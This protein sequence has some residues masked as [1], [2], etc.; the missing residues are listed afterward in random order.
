MPAS[1]SK[2]PLYSQVHKLLLDRIL[3]GFWKPGEKLPAETALAQH[4]GVS[5]GTVR[6]AVELLVAE[7]ILVRREG[8]GTFVTTYR[9]AGYWNRFQPFDTVEASERY[10][11]RRFILLETKA[12]PVEA[13]SA[14]GLADGT[15]MIHIV[16]HMVRLSGPRK[17]I[18]TIVTVDEL[19]LRCDVFK[20]L[21]EA[22]LL[23]RFL[24]SDS[25]YKFYDREF[26]VVVTRQK[27]AV[28]CEDVDGELARALRLS[29]PMRALRL[30][31]V[32]YA[33]GTE[34]VEYRI[35]RSRAQEARLIFDLN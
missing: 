3:T 7:N 29:S 24:P 28:S 25:L 18:E 11:L 4:F 26:G 27:C 31:R 12:S 32:S 21:N 9:T 17:S 35:Y 10:D 2:N 34:P 33:F 19:Y 22:F 13:S 1:V 16:R 5:L 23:T 20:G 8:A 15:P 6:H 14:L 30:D